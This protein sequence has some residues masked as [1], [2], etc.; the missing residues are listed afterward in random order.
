MNETTTRA[1]FTAEMHHGS[2][3]GVRCYGSGHKDRATYGTCDGCGSPVA[4]TESGRI[5]PVGGS[6]GYMRT[7]ACWGDEHVCDPETAAAQ[8]ALK[9]TKIDAGEIVKGQTVTVVKGRKVPVGT[10]GTISWIGEDNYGKAR[11]GIRTEAGET[12][13]TAESNVEVAS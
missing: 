13:F 2:K 6:Y 1:G 8:A 5:M 10:T 12:V 3:A 11:V 4:K 9:A 7:Y